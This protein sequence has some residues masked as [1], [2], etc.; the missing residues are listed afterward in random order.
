MDEKY[1]QIL[2]D[3]TRAIIEEAQKNESFRIKIEDILSCQTDLSLRKA[4]KKASKGGRAAN[5]RDPAVL[6]PISLIAEGEDELVR[7]LN[8]LTDKELKDIIADFAMDPSKLAM[9]WK[10]RNRLIS[11]IVDASRRRA[12]KGDAFRNRGE[13]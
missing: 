5:R 7:H 4:E 8:V 11:H 6:D 10:D 1:I 9:K 2:K 3:L 13:E 12:S